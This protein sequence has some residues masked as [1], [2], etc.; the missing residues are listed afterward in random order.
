TSAPGSVGRGQCAAKISYV[1]RPSTNARGRPMTS[2]TSLPIGSPQCPTDQPPWVTPPLRSSS[3]P[4]GACITPSS[5]T[6]VVTLSLLTPTSSHAAPQTHGS[7]DDCALSNSREQS[8][9]GRPR[10]NGR[11]SAVQQIAHRRL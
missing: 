1:F 10:G 2:S 11:T 5:V 6:N 8:S 3:G 4:P 7:T 9:H